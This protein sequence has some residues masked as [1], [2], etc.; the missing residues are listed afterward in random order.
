MHVLKQEYLLFPKEI[1]LSRQQI[2][3]FMVMWKI[4]LWD[5]AVLDFTVLSK[6]EPLFSV[7]QDTKHVYDH[8]SWFF[9]FKIKIVHSKLFM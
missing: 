7:Y 1:P 6:R 5:I 8:V 4:H 2:K 3:S 9:F